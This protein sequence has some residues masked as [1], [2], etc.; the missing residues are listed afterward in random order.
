M[1]AATVAVVVVGVVAVLVVA[2]MRRPRHDPELDA[3][4]K[5]AAI[6]C[7]STQIA[8]LIRRGAGPNHQESNGSTPLAFAVL[9]PAP[10]KPAAV[11]TLIAHGADP[12]LLVGS[13]PHTS[14]LDYA[15]RLGDEP[16]ISAL[17]DGGGNVNG[18]DPR[19]YTALH[20]AALLSADGERA[21]EM[22]GKAALLLQR[23]ADPNL[24]AK[25][26]KTPLD[27]AK[28][29]GDPGIIRLCSGA[30]GGAATR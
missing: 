8:E 10:S 15:V 18:A 25:N 16:T 24:H 29:G 14:P 2:R 5:L 22:E 9:S 1:I 27:L 19:G 30:P 4:L 7:D 13:P 6:A 20:Y 21:R 26:G 17:L 12:N 11:A 23:G 28:E 3:K